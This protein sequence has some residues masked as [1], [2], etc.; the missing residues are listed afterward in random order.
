M[1]ARRKRQDAQAIEVIREHL[2]AADAHNREVL[3][4]AIARMELRYSRDL[5]DRE[6]IQVSAETAI[7]NLR[8]S[9]TTSAGDVARSLAQVANMCAMVAEQIETERLERRALTEAIELLARPHAPALE[10]GPRVI[11]G[12]VFASPELSHDGEI[13]IVDDHD[14]DDYEDLEARAEPEEQNDRAEAA[15]HNGA[16]DDMWCREDD[17]WVGGVEIADISNDHDTIRYWIRRRSDGY[18][19]PRAFD[20]NELRFLPEAPTA[21][22]GEPQGH[23]S[24]T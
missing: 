24:Q 9:V 19:F 13:S 5:E 23:W 20:A 22:N 6:R 3:A 8:H 16:S 18:I 2:A 17:E 1:F 12:T 21:A 11:G 10:E 4:A 7:H 15:P 14:D